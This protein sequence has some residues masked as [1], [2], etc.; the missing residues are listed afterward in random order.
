[1]A[2][3][4]D[5]GGREGPMM[6]PDAAAASS[7]DAAAAGWNQHT[8][9]IHDWLHTVTQT[10]LDD[11][12]IAAGARVLDIAAGAGDQTLD[13]AL[14]VGPKGH[15]LA[16]DVSPNILALA[17]KNLQVA[18]LSQVSIRVADAQSLDL[19]GA[20]FDSAICRL[21]LMFCG[22]PLEALTQIRAALRPGGRFSALVFGLPENNPC[23]TILFKTARQHAGLPLMLSRPDDGDVV[24]GPL[25]SLARPGLLESLLREAGLIDVSVRSVSAPFHAPS[26]AH[27]VDFLRSSAAPLI[28][29]LAS[30]SDAAQQ[31]A[32]DDMTQKLQV[33]ATPHGWVGPNELL[34]CVA[35]APESNASASASV[36][37][38]A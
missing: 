16:T 2:A 27:Y 12:H 10:M 19:A 31:A 38:T 14:R 24:A 11:A 8:A 29:V 13:I 9:M 3:H 22:D 35:V 18:G 32:W 25:L 26:A 30:L 15:V 6:P 36:V 21:G 17:Q 20:D 34:H 1:M 7:W 4:R 28:D 23:L 37:S 5:S 33:F